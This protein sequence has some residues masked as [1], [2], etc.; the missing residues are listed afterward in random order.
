MIRVT[1]LNIEFFDHERPETVVYDFDLTLHEGEI[2]GL[3]GESG[4]GKSMSALAIAGLLSRKDMKKR[5]EILFEGVNLLDCDRKTLRKFQGNEIG[6]IFQEPMTS[7]NPVKKIGWQV[8]EAL[9]LHTEL[10]K[11][12]RKKRAIEMLEKVE[13]HNPEQVYEQ[14]PHEL[15]GGMRQR[16]MIA[17]AMIC[18]P[19]LLIA[20]EPTTALDVTIQEQIVAPEKDQS[21]KEDSY[22]FYLS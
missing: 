10:S 7:L 1:D 11:E 2:V 19:K 13:L 20:D 12:E 3:V 6:M 4:S 21:G 15:S 8:E 9:R 17:A 22:S 14:Y 5:G 16:V 18:D